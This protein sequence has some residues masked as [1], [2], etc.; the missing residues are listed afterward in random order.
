MAHQTAAQL[1]AGMASVLSAPKDEG[2]VR[3][4][5]CR[6]ARGVRE[7]LSEGQLDTEQGLIGDDWINRPGMYLDTPS[8][9][10]QVT[11]MNARAAELISGDPR[12]E[13]WAQCGDQLYIDLDI[14]EANL[15]AGTHI[16]VGGAILEVQAEPHTGCVQ[17]RGWWGSDALRHIS[18]RE[19]LALR[20]RGA[21]TR[22][23]RSGVVRAGDRARKIQPQDHRAV[24]ST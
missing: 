13:T 9:H 22:V 17:F 3:L 16:E 19:G 18:T 8:P 12:P 11:V 14:S 24:G 5:V 7:I 6:P 23:V 10:A 1:E 20:M 2:T 15:P 4:V 21:N